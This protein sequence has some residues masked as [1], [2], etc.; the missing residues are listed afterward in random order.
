M[1]NVSSFSTEQEGGRLSSVWVR[2]LPLSIAEPNRKLP[3]YLHFIW[4]VDKQRL[5]ISR[6]PI[7]LTALSFFCKLKNP[8]LYA[9]HLKLNGP[10]LNIFLFLFLYSPYMLCVCIPQTLGYLKFS[11]FFNNVWHQKWLEGCSVSR[12]FNIVKNLINVTSLGKE[13]R[14]YD[15]SFSFNWLCAGALEGL[16]L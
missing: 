5:S 6:N 11:L 16:K 15:S 10:S 12:I 2:S 1:W 4:P 13:L 7:V 8:C 3:L 14:A 9:R